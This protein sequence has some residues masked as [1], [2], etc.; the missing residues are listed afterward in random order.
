MIAS[1]ITTLVYSGRSSIVTSFIRQQ[2][3][4]MEARQ[5]I[6][7]SLHQE[8]IEWRRNMPFPLPSANSHVPHLSTTWYDFNYYTHL[9]MLYRPSP[10]LPTLDQPRVQILAE[11]AAMALRQASSMHRQERF[12]YN[13]LNLLS[14]F[15]STLCLVYAIT[16]QPNELVVVLE[17]SRATDDLQLAIELFE[18]LSVKFSSAK[19]VLK[20]VQQV[21]QRYQDICSSAG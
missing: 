20:M 6:V 8:L 18:I 4:N 19:R 17:E 11:A 2:D 12:A 5:E 13:W 10:L 1:K 16:A 3:T 9:A 15:M 14:V 7:R 21:I